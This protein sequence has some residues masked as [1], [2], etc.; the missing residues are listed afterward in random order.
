LGFNETSVDQEGIFPRQNPPCPAAG[1]LLACLVCLKKS[2]RTGL[3][4]LSGNTYLAPGKHQP[5]MEGG[6]IIFS[7]KIFTQGSATTRSGTTAGKAGIR[8]KLSRP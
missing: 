2:G 7:I 3:S 6:K 4:W 1:K 8:T 5:E